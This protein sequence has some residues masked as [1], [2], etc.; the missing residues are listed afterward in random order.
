MIAFDILDKIRKQREN[1][2]MFHRMNLHLWLVSMLH[3]VVDIIAG[4]L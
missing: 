2:S 4:L 3:K 1:N